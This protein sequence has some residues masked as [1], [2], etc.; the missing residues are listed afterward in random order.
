MK[1]IV[2]RICSW[3]QSW[4]VH[5]KY[6][7]RNT[8]NEPTKS[9]IIGMIGNAMGVHDYDSELYDK[10]RCSPM[11]V[12]VEREG[13]VIKDYHIASG[14]RNLQGKSKTGSLP[15]DRYYLQNAFFY[16]AMTM[17]NSLAEEVAYA[18]RHPQSQLYFGRKCCVPVFPVLV[19]TYDSEDLIDV[20]KSIKPNSLEKE[21][22]EQG[23]TEY[24]KIKRFIFETTERTIMG[25]DVRDI[26]ISEKCY[27][28]RRVAQ[29]FIAVN[30]EDAE[31]T[32]Q[33]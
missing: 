21:F 32:S 7:I 9:G 18:V 23:F 6:T 27:S 15:T 12:R 8:N 3:L 22:I 14:F 26:P 19:G 30:T 20:L 1:T 10:L 13:D 2:F 33:G 11:A 29:E 28:E 17:D 25:D 16:V 4:G 5:S 31:C 24:N